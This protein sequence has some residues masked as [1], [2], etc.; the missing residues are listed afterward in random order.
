MAD[1][2]GA[3]SGGG[4]PFRADTPAPVR[5]ADAS[6]LLPIAPSGT[7]LST[8]PMSADIA[9][10]IA[11][12]KADVAP[13]IS[14][15]PSYRTRSGSTGLDQLNEVTAPLAASFS[16][17]G[18]GRMTVT[19]EPTLLSNGQLQGSTAAEQQFGT[20][21]F[22]GPLPG[23]QHAQG[24]GLSAAYKY[25]W[26]AADIGTTPLG[27]RVENVVGGV[28]V[29]P[30]LTEG[31]R[32]RA[33]AERR[34]IT[35]SLLSYAGTVDTGTG[36][37]FGGV[38]RTRGHAQ[39]ELTAGLANFYAGGGY[40][41]LTGQNVATNTETE[42]GAG[43]SY[44]V[45]HNGTDELRTGLDLVYFTY[46]KNLD[47]FTLGQGGYFSPQSYFAAVVPLTFTQRLQNLTWSLG[48]S[49]GAQSYTE[50]STV[51]FPNNPGLQEQLD[52]LAAGKVTPSLRVGGLFRYDHAGNWTE[53][54]ATVFARYIFNAEQ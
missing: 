30:E 46:A 10:A 11:T 26:L 54:L 21:V 9:R 33:V 37:T 17:G 8:D 1:L 24:I 7:A 43:G 28:E 19:A 52:A 48:G 41:Q 23:N 36:Q 15:S 13:D 51:V 14:L 32:L 31:L 29:S 50:N 35:D 53:T 42:F 3:P 25:Q 34:P 12:A 4:N 20:L 39:L 5:V 2:A 40:S 47:H 18:Y 38:V 22:G 44:P 16:P 45:Y 27:F 6:G 49:V